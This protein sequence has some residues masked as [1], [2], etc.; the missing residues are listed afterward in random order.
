M[1]Q[2]AQGSTVLILLINFRFV[3]GAFILMGAGCAGAFSICTWYLCE[4][5]YSDIRQGAAG[6][7][8]RKRNKRETTENVELGQLDPGTVDGLLLSQTSGITIPQEEVQ[9]SL[10]EDD[11]AQ[12]NAEI[13]PNVEDNRD[14]PPPPYSP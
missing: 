5:N 11:G 7:N 12:G 14:E 1:F 3:I 13:S 6:N 2:N 10:H 8:A 4:A 9:S